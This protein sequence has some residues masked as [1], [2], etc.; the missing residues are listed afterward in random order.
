MTIGLT[1]PA[2]ILADGYMKGSTIAK[3]T[4]LRQNSATRL[5]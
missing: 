3:R 4:L 2:M 5:S 1:M